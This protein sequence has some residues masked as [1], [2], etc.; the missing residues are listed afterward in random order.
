MDCCSLVTYFD[1]YAPIVKWIRRDAA[2]GREAA[3]WSVAT[4]RQVDGFPLHKSGKAPGETLVSVS[5]GVDYL[6]DLLLV[7]LIVWEIKGAAG[8]IPQLCS[9]FSQRC[10]VCPC[11]PKTFI[12]VSCCCSSWLLPLSA[13]YLASHQ[14]PDF[15]KWPQWACQKTLY[16]VAHPR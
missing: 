12:L 10:S 5:A 9:T 7:S 16:G 8:D 4:R 14:S 3:V 6:T 11:G 15:K 13:F 1:K 2:A